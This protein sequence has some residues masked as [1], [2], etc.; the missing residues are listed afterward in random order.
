MSIYL[1]KAIFLNRAPFDLLELDFYDNEISVLTGANGKGKTTIIS[2]IVDAFYEMAK[3]GFPQEF[4][5]KEYKYYRI[6]TPLQLLSKEKVSIVYLRFQSRIIIDYIE[7]RNNCTEA[8]YDKIKIK[9][10]IPYS[11]IIDK[12][13]GTNVLKYISKNFTKEISIELF[14]NNLLTYFPA[15]R[16][17]EPGYLNN[18]YQFQLDFN[19]KIPITGYLHNPIEIRSGLSY[20]SNWMMDLALDN[21]QYNVELKDIEKVLIELKTPDKMMFNKEMI[22]QYFKNIIQLSLVKKN[23]TWNNI[24]LIL[25]NAISAKGFSKLRFGIARRDFGGARIQ[26]IDANTDETII[27]ALPNLSSGESSILCLFGELLRQADRNQR[28]IELSDITGIVLV[29][30]IDKHLHI[31]LQKEVLPVLLKLFPNVQ[32]II[33]SHSPFLCMGLSETVEERARILD[34]D[35]DGIVK[36]LSLVRQYIDVYEMMVKE[37][38]RFRKQF[39]TLR[40]QVASKEKPIIITEGSTDW[41]H[42][43]HAFRKL[44]ENPIYFERYCEM[45]FEF[46]EYEPQTCTDSNSYRIDMGGSELLQCC[47]RFVKIRQDNK[48]VIFIADRDDPDV[49]KEFEDEFR[50]FKNWGKNV[51]SLVLPV[52]P[53]RQHTPKICIEHYYTDDEIKTISHDDGKDR[54]LFLG[55][56]FNSRGLYNADQQKYICLALNKCGPNKINIIDGSKDGRVVSP[57]RIDADEI[58]N[59]A[60]S[61]ASFVQNILDEKEGFNNF[62]LSQFHLVFDIIKEILEES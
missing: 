42:L 19:N 8:E 49:L 27:P 53:H 33:T 18:P 40:D 26:I 21:L 57:S 43:K 29:D 2:H 28:D 58:E 14:N 11:E 61:K 1:Q 12:L 54:R 16:Y 9:D 39:L 3:M 55:N 35:N 44:K 23:K 41:K 37:N 45:D 60:L 22:P 7:I 51:Y 6:S 47:K 50:C 24:N 17:E 38:E 5:G 30:E 20:F 31:K 25:T 62:N 48:K 15:Y 10:K 56:E 4:E 34:L 46:L 52:A 13:K 36:D 59:Y 32:F